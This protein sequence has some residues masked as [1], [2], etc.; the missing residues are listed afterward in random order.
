MAHYRIFAVSRLGEKKVER[1]SKWTVLYK[2]MFFN[3]YSIKHFIKPTVMEKFERKWAFLFLQFVFR[4]RGIWLTDQSELFFTIKDS[5]KSLWKFWLL[6]PWKNSSLGKT[7]DS[8]S[9]E[10][11]NN[12]R[13]WKIRNIKNLMQGSERKLISAGLLLHLQ[14]FHLRPSWKK[15]THYL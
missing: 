6:S 9:R 7:C 5:S 2:R 1:N 15:W 3:E 14:N 11:S 12:N 4:E 13:L 8:I 10:H